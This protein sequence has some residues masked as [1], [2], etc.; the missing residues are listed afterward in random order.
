VTDAGDD[1]ANV[2]VV[3]YQSGNAYIYYVTAADDGL[4]TGADLTAA[5][6][7]I[8]LVGVING[9]T[10]GALTAAEFIAL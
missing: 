10:A 8:D 5:A 6:A 9:V 3:A 4:A 7:D 2:F 1:G